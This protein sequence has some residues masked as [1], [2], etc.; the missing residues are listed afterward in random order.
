MTSNTQTSTPVTEVQPPVLIPNAFD[1]E[2]APPKSWFKRTIDNWCSVWPESAAEKIAQL[3]RI[4]IPSMIAFVGSY[5]CL[6]YYTMLPYIMGAGLAVRVWVQYDC[7]YVIHRFSIYCILKFWLAFYGTRR[8]YQLAKNRLYSFWFN[9]QWKILTFVVAALISAVIYSHYGKPS[10]RERELF[11]KRKQDKAVV[12]GKIRA[13][14]EIANETTDPKQ[15]DN[16]LKR[17]ATIQANNVSN[18]TTSLLTPRV[19][20]LM[21]L[22]MMLLSICAGWAAQS[23]RPLELWQT[24]RTFL[25]AASFSIQAWSGKEQHCSSYGVDC[26]TSTAKGPSP[27]LQCCSQRAVA[28]QSV[29]PLTYTV[30]DISD[31]PDDYSQPLARYLVKNSKDL[32]SWFLACPVYMQNVLAAGIGVKLSELLAKTVE[33]SHNKNVWKISSPHQFA[34]MLADNRRTRWPHELSSSDSEEEE[35]PSAE[36]IDVENQTVPADDEERKEESD[37]TPSQVLLGTQ[38]QSVPTPL[39]APQPQVSIPVAHP[40]HPFVVESEPSIPDPNENFVVGWL[41]KLPFFGVWGMPL[42]FLIG[43]SLIALSYYL[44][45]RDEVINESNVS[46]SYTL[47]EFCPHEQS[48][49]KCKVRNCVFKHTDKPLSPN[50]IENEGRGTMSRHVH[51]A[52]HSRSGAN[53]TGTLGMRQAEEDRTALANKRQNTNRNDNDV[54]LVRRKTRFVGYDDQAALKELLQHGSAV[55]VIFTRK[56]ATKATIVVVKTMQEFEKLRADSNILRPSLVVSKLTDNAKFR[57]EALPEHQKTLVR[58]ARSLPVPLDSWNVV[59]K[60]LKD[61]DIHDRDGSLRAIM[62]KYVLEGNSMT[63]PDKVL[64]S[65]SGSSTVAVHDSRVL[66]DDTLPIREKAASAVHHKTQEAALSLERSKMNNLDFSEAPT[67]TIVANVTA[68]KVSGTFVPAKLGTPRYQQDAKESI[69]QIADKYNVPFDQVANRPQ[70][71]SLEVGDRI[72]AFNNQPAVFSAS[73]GLYLYPIDDETT[74]PGKTETPVISSESSDSFGAV[75]TSNSYAAL[76]DA[77][78]ELDS[79]PTQVSSLGAW[80][81]K[82]KLTPVVAAKTVETLKQHGLLVTN[83]ARTLPPRHSASSINTKG[84]G[85]FALKTDHSKNLGMGRII[86]GNAIST[87]AHIFIP[88]KKGDTS[89]NYEDLVFIVPGGS[90]P[91]I[92]LL[93]NHPLI[94][95]TQDFARVELSKSDAEWAHSQ[96]EPIKVVTPTGKIGEKYWGLAATSTGVKTIPC[97][98]IADPITSTECQT[99]IVHDGDTIGGHSGMHLVDHFGNTVAIHKGTLPGSNP[100]RNVAVPVTQNL[101]LI[102]RSNAANQPKNW[103]RPLPQ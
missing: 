31:R 101:N 78:E 71:D 100:V 41:R 35:N 99:F 68:S 18:Q 51:Q 33:I 89:H 17:I 55:E 102:M 67:A 23:K 36:H 69:Q 96:V 9:Y 16:I 49:G 52:S 42:L 77:D 72:V 76:S 87:S 58:I 37:L 62:N 73:R 88:M 84:A 22:A 8:L 59:V 25:T 12:V 61:D 103:H 7:A 6:L 98:L 24:F 20:A 45:N 27:C 10:R 40:I 86:G 95:S 82:P 26:K 30:E 28:H 91:R 66:Q 2:E 54:S 32:P 19:N 93:P 79:V 83:E 1:Q 14:Q 85:Y 64:K 4:L 47:G 21:H 60:A 74:S 56:G 43:I 97:T 57:V 81:Q 63:N 94:H 38:G 13:L 65:Y 70:Y 90:E 50:A 92:M 80:V 75:A 48:T 39:P 3:D 11:Y 34:D 15:A 44:S 29:T 5:L 53:K 46:D